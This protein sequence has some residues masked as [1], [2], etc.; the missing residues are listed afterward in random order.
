LQSLRERLLEGPQGV[1]RLLALLPGKFFQQRCFARRESRARNRGEIAL[2]M[3]LEVD[4]DAQARACLQQ[5]RMTA[6]VTH[7][8]GREGR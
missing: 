6:A 1:E 4:A 5:R 3:R 2:T 8:L 7:A